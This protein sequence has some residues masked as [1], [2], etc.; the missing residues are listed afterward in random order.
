VSFEEVEAYSSTDF[1]AM[2]ANGDGGIDRDEATKAAAADKGT[3]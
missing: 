1:A 3:D 2:D